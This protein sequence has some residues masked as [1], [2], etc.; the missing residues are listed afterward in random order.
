MH[1]TTDL[2][3]RMNVNDRMNELIYNYENSNL[4]IILCMFLCDTTVHVYDCIPGVVLICR[5]KKS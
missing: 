3:E 4:I 1:A 2:N 5:V